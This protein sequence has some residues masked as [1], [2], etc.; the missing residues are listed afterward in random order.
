MVLQTLHW[1][2]EIRDPKKEL[3]E[4]PSGRAGRGKELQMALQLVDSLSSGWN[5][6]RYHDT[7]QEQIRELVKAKAE[8]EEVALAEEAP[9]ATNVVDLM[10]ALQGSL[11]AARTSRSEQPSSTRKTASGRRETARSAAKKAAAQKAPPKQGRG[12]RSR[13]TRRRELEKLSKTDLYQ[14]ASEQDL[15]GRSKMSR[16]QLIDALA[17][18]GR[19]SKKSAA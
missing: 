10:Q 1:A 12:Q 14:Q 18:A 5:P 7:Y 11:D 17:R 3:P 19:S 2:D 4:L 13:T 16:D 6:A 15:P 9:A 8:G